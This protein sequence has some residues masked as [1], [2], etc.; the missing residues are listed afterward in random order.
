MS[1]KK[2]KWFTQESVLSCLSPNGQITI[3][4]GN[5]GV[6]VA[7]LPFPLGGGKERQ[8]EK[9]QLLVDAVHFHQNKKE[10]LEE[11]NEC[12][13]YFKI[14]NIEVRN[15]ERIKKLKKLIKQI[16]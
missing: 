6:P 10:I 9:A 15:T 5:I 12:L 8:R 16:Q 1:A 7:V 11:M 2:L 4:H 3:K 14:Q 13:Q